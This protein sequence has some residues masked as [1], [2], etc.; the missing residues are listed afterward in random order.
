MRE[1]RLGPDVLGG[2]EPQGI[3][4][5]GH[6]QAARTTG[7]WSLVSCTVSPGFRFEGFDLVPPGFDIPPRR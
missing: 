4:P 6:W 1:I 5:E 7:G 3:V 2:E